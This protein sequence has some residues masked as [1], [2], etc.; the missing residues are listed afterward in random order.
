MARPRKKNTYEDP[1]DR[2]EAGGKTAQSSHLGPQIPKLPDADRRTSQLLGVNGKPDV[3]KTLTCWY[4][5]DGDR[6][7]K[8]AGECKFAHFDTGRVSQDPFIFLQAKEPQAEPALDLKRLTCAYWAAGG[9]RKSESQCKYAH[10]DTGRLANTPKST[11]LP[12]E[13]LCIVNEVCRVPTDA[14]L[15]RSCKGW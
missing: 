5:S 9:C 8:S 13:W 4:W 15:L 11:G 1:K 3:A 14:N 10:H 6:C 2:G 12:G 7:K